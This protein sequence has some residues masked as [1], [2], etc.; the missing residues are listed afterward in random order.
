MTLGTRSV[1]RCCCCLESLTS[2]N[3]NPAVQCTVGFFPFH[4]HCWFSGG[5]S[6][7]PF[8]GRPLS[9]EYDV[10]KGE[11]NLRH[12]FDP[13]LVTITEIDDDVALGLP[14]VKFIE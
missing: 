6:A 4:S 1:A 14:D 5:R 7:G 8:Q 13:D 3:L 9:Q 2:D 10:F 12:V 11:V